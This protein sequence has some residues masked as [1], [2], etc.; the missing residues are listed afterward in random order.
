MAVQVAVVEE[1]VVTVV[2]VR[3]CWG[4]RLPAGR[5]A[6]ACSTRR[7]RVRGRTGLVTCPSRCAG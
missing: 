1:E 7:S 3:C 2:V 4:R 5:W 6:E